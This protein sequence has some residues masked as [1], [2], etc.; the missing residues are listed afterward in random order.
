MSEIELSSLL[1]G[2]K[3]IALSSFAIIEGRKN[4]VTFF[5]KK[6]LSIVSEADIETEKY[7]RDSLQALTPDIPVYGE[8]LGCDIADDC[9]LY[10]LIDP[11]DGTTWY[12]LGMPVYGSLIALIQNGEPILGSIGLPAIN[13]LV[14]AGK[15]LGCFIHSGKNNGRQLLSKPV[16]TAPM[17]VEQA[18]ITASGMHGTSTWIENGDTPWSLISVLDRA[19]LFK[20]SADCIQHVSV[21]NGASDAAIDTIMKPW[22]SAAIIICAREAGLTVMD[23]NGNQ[24]GILKSGNL[25]TAKS[26]HLAKSLVKLLTPL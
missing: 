9:Q 12:K 22:D 6:D 16:Q 8:E 21:L 23:L 11:I 24:R 25:L 13:T 10:W 17:C 3:Q 2:V 19:K 18:T 4:E 26:E 1:Q 14:Y 5:E 7:I 20:F 15:D